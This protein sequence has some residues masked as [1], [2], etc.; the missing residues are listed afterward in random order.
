MRS[1]QG[2]MHLWLI[3]DKLIFLSIN[4][5]ALIIEQKLLEVGI[6]DP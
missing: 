3:F 1:T 6:D 5:Y 2:Y 4:I